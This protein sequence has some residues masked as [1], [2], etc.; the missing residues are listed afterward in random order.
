[1]NRMKAFLVMVIALYVD[2]KSKLSKVCLKF[3]V[4]VT[5]LYGFDA[6]ELKYGLQ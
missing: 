5:I 6:Y 1:M 2:F 3:L 4:I